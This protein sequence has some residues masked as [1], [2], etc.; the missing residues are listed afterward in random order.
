MLLEGETGFLFLALAHVIPDSLSFIA[1]IFLPL[2][3]LSPIGHL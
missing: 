2:F 3:D 1:V